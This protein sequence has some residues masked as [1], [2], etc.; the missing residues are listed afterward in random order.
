MSLNGEVVA[1]G[2]DFGSGFVSGGVSETSSFCA[3]DPAAC[4]VV[5]LVT[6]NYPEETSWE[7]ANAITGEIILSGDG[8]DGSFGTADC[9]SGCT[10][11][12]AC[13]YDATADI[14]DGS[15][16][17]SCLG[18]TDSA[19]AN[20]NPEATVD[21]GDCIYCEP[22]QFILNVDMADSFGDGWGGVEYYLYDLSSGALVDSG[23]I[24][25][26]FIGDG[27]T[28]GLDLI[29]VAPGCY[30]FQ[31][32]GGGFDADEASVSLSDQ[33]GT[34]YGTVTGTDVDF[35]I[36]YTLT[37]QCGF[38]GCTDA[39]AN[40]F[41]PS[42]TID[43]GSCLLPPA[44]D[45]VAN[46]EALAC[47]LIA[48]GT[49]QNANDNEGLE[50]LEWGNDVLGAS[51]VWYVI[52][53]DA[54][55]QITLSTCDTPTND[56]TTDY[57]TS[58][59]IAI[60][61]Q[62]LDGTLTCIATNNDGCD[63]GFHS[64]ITWTAST[65]EDYYARVE[66]GG[67]SEFALSATC[68]PDQ[69]D[70]P[71]NDDCSG[72]ISQVTGETFTGNLCGANA[73]EVS[74]FTAGNATAYG[75]YFTFNSANY[76]TFLFDATNVSNDVLGFMMFNGNTCDDLTDFVGCQFAGTCAGPVDAFLTLTP[77]T[78]YYFLI[79]TTDQDACGDF[80]FTTTGILL[81]CTDP[82][83][84]NYDANA[85][86]DDG[87]CDFT[88]VTPVNDSCA[89]AIELACNATTS[90]STGGS[91][92]VGAPLNVAGCEAAPGA[93]VWYTFV[94]DSSYHTLSTCGSAI[95]SKINIYSADIECGGGGIDA[96]PA[97][98]CGEGLVTTN[99]SVGGGTWDSEITWSL[100]DAAGV[101]VASGA[102]PT[103][104]SL[105][106]PAGDYTLT[107]NDSYG[108][109]W[110][111]ASATFT[112]G[113]GDIM[114]FATL[115]AGSTGTA[116]IS[117]APYSTDPI[118]IA[119]DF[120]C[121]ASAT[122]S[123]GTGVCTLFDADDVSFE[124]I[125]EPGLLYYVYV[126]AQDTDGNPATDDNGAFD[127]EFTCAP[128]L[129]GCLDPAACNY[130]PDANVDNGDCEVFSCVCPDETG[131]PVQFYMFD[132]FGDGWDGATY[133]V[134]DLDGNVVASGNLDDAAFSVDENNSVGPEFGYDLFCLQS[135][136]Y[137]LV[138]TDGLYPNE[139]SWEIRLADGSVLT[140]GTPTE[141]Q[142][143][144]I[145]G[146]ICGCTAE[147]ACNYDE[148]ATSDDGSCEYESCGGC[149]DD[150]ACN[151]DGAA[152]ID[153]GSCCYDN[154]VTV[155]L[156]DQFSDGWDGAIYT[157]T[158][159]DGTEVGSGTLEFG[160]SGAD[161]YCLADGCYI[162]TVTEGSFPSEVSWNIVG[163][164]GGIVS[165]GA[166]ESVTFNVGSGDQCVVGCDIACACN[167]NENTNISD[168]TLCVFDGCSGCTYEGSAL[169]DPSAVVDDGSCT[170]EFANPCPAD[171][172]GDG[173]VSTADLLEFLT[174]F[175]AVC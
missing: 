117:V 54:N 3:E 22:G 6:D 114:G 102:A 49:L 99:Y 21:N 15:C 56:G 77:N 33:F 28:T 164:F 156:A 5:T 74:I 82:A 66:G 94:G 145:G 92:N 175:G 154:C 86:Q 113:L 118:F 48:S 38:E 58:T 123:D 18:C 80:E 9:A 47:G 136:C 148:A 46:A 163:A 73:E 34:M 62:D 124:F 14:N 116:T 170:F 162:I 112:N 155:N 147:G 100:S 30:N 79:Y 55:Q 83:A 36:D 16:D 90:G 121:V 78:D 173:S 65:G 17:Y 149:T 157:I 26:A 142:T 125:S 140:S 169:Y 159:T 128:V 131:T 135:G 19:A 37:G 141:G 172:N 25:T 59:D 7:L 143:I 10:D 174:A 42:A 95:D 60:F 151:Y 167:Y 153:D 40:N 107:M 71:A 122:S 52:N 152:L 20:Y 104:A 111:G 88:G 2:G 31:T 11:A 45:D 4:V 168:V 129:E 13:N 120:T 76:D 119:G 160:T 35:G 133:E 87:S 24:E 101:E 50:G 23:S 67:G 27:L 41:N 144:S 161:D 108:D 43:D 69:A 138:V 57:A 63:L 146:A 166:G 12:G 39:T 134:S 84:N 72:A 110:N 61:K 68:N 8:T 93:G 1:S 75:V 51:G 89:D 105:C 109:G 44:N 81:G 171:L 96:P 106:L 115:E 127:L 103:S 32:I 132:S 158:T 98:A 85:T 126:G 139:V 53:S 29:C 64:T 91:T 130:N 97:D 137:N 70:S 165:G 150:T